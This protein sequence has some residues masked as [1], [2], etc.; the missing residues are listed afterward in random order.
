MVL[1]NPPW[2][3]SAELGSLESQNIPQK[4][5]SM[6]Y[7]GIDAITGKS[8]FDV[9]EWM[10]N[11]LLGALQGMEFVVSLLCK[12]VVARRIMAR[13]AQAQWPLEGELRCI[14]ATTHFDASVEA[15][16]LTLRAD[17]RPSHEVSLRWPM[18]AALPSRSPASVVGY[19]DGTITPDIDAFS[20]TRHLAGHCVPEWRSG[21]K[22]DCSAVMELMV[23][24]GG[25]VSQGGGAVDIE[26]DHVFPLMKGS[27]VAHGRWP[28]R[29]ALLVPQRALG[30]DTR[31]LRETA[32]RTWAYLQAHRRALDARKSTIYAGKPPFS[33][34]G[35]GSYTF[36]PWKV[37]I[38]GLYK[39]LHFFLV[40]PHQGRPVVFDDTTYFLPFETEAAART[41]HAALTSGLARDFFEARVFWDDKRPINKG[42]LQA[43]DLSSVGS[44]SSWEH[45]RQRPPTVW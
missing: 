15:V 1:G 20:R 26:P 44:G 14:D 2:V 33:V 19:I 30:Q 12:F 16:L 23:E 11:R 29:R 9:S 40:G 35:V 36:A 38:A 28:P 24:E 31:V 8:N 32:P 5:N 41:A 43:L 10:L 3:T 27:D 45:P 17:V 6:S 42:V 21:L 22:H 25:L 4:Q 34:F 7:A 37:A 13:A 39:K 18:Y